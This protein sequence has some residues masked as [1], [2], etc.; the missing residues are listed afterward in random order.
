MKQT[1][2]EEMALFHRLEAAGVPIESCVEAELRSPDLRIEQLGD[3]LTNNVTD[4]RRGGA[5][6]QAYVRLTCHVAGPIYLK[7]VLLSAGWDEAVELLSDPQ[8][9]KSGKPYYRLRNGATFERHLCINHLFSA[10]PLRRGDC[11]EGFLLAESM[12]QVPGHFIEHSQV[13]ALLTIVDQFANYHSAELLLALER[14]NL[15]RP[16]PRAQGNM[17]SEGADV[18]LT[19]PRD[20]AH[21]RYPRST[22]NKGLF[23]RNEV[24]EKKVAG[25]GKID[26]ELPRVGTDND[27]ASLQ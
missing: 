23:E 16:Y 6:Y 8:E 26:G 20:Q 10:R 5:L 22:T 14:T 11:I 13:K 9:F 27:K 12:R 2:K 7:E 4:V 19:V 1:K 21:E 24:V 25:T 18:A 17:T 15:A 3:S